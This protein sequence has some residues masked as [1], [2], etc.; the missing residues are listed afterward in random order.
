MDLL[1]THHQGLFQYQQFRKAIA[2]YYARSHYFTLLW[3]GCGAEEVLVSDIEAVLQSLSTVRPVFHSE[4]DFQ[5]ALAWA[6]RDGQV[7]RDVRLDRP[8]GLERVYVDIWGHTAHGPLALG[9]NMSP[10]D[11]Q[12]KWPESHL[13]CRTDRTWPRFTTVRLYQGSRAA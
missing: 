10:G 2:D 13:T 3:R 9:L 7:V 8:H 11:A 4:A 6:L 5:H 12:S 1:V